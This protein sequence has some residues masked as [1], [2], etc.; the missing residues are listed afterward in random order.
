MKL[1]CAFCL[2]DYKRKED[3]AEAISIIG[4]EAVC[5]DHLGYTDNSRINVFLNLLRGGY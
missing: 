1:F 2:Y 5:K 3:A 4:G